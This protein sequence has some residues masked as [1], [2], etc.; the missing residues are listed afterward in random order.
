MWIIGLLIGLIVGGVIDRGEGAFFGAVLGTIAG[1]TL[2]LMKRTNVVNELQQRISTLEDG[3]FEL[4]AQLAALGGAGGQ[5]PIAER[6][7]APAPTLETAP[8]EAAEAA[9]QPAAATETPAAA[10]QP[11]TAP[12][13]AATG[14][15]RQP[16]ESS[17]SV[18]PAPS[19]PDELTRLWNWLTGGNALVRVGVVV[20]FFGVAFLLKYAY[21]HTH[22]PIEVR[23]TGVAIGAIV[24]LV[25]GWRLRAR[26]PVY[27]L[28]VQGGGIGVL[29]LVVFGSFRLFKLLPGEAA[30]VLLIAIAVLSAM[31]AILQ[32][33]QSLAVLAVSGGFLAPVLAST[34][35][36]SHVM[37]FSY[38]AVL[39]LGIL[40][41][42]F[43]KAWRPLNVLGFFFTFGIGSLWGARFYRDELF[44]S[45]EPFLV[46][47]TLMYIA[48][49]IMFAFRQ[50]PRLKHYVDSTL[51][52]G[53]PLVAFG[54]QARLVRPFEYGAA[55]SAVALAALYLGLAALLYQRKRETL[56]MLVE[57]FLALGIIFITLAIPL[58]VD[59]RWTSAAWA[60]E[61]AA[62]Y[63]VGVHQ[64]RRAPRVFG[65]L[66]QF[67][68]GVA[69][70]GDF[71]STTGDTPVLN[72]FYMGTVFIAL[73]GLFSNY[74]IERHAA[75][76][77]HMAMQV[78]IAVF[79]WGLA[80][81]VF[82]GLNEIEQHVPRAQRL[83][84][85]LLFLSVSCTVFSVL[86]G[87]GWWIARF[88]ALGLAP[89]MAIALLLMYLGSLPAHPLAGFG[90][91]A[92]PLAFVLHFFILRRDETV[93][94]TQSERGI[95]QLHYVAVAHAAGVWLLAA[96]GAL[97]LSWQID[98]VVASTRTWS[99]IAWALV[100]VVL[101]I[102]GSSRTVQ[103]HWP[104]SVNKQSYLWN[105][106]LPL[107][108]FV[109]VWSLYANWVSDGDPAPLPY[110][111]FLNPLD[112]AQ[113]LVFAAAIAWWRSLQP[114]GIKQA[115]EL[116]DNWKWGLFGG[117]VF[118]WLNGVL[119]RSL[120][121]WGG[122]PHDFG[123]M[124][125]SALAQTAVSIFWTVLALAAML[126]ATRR[127]NRWLW[128]TGAALMAVVVVK[129][130]VIDLAKVG[131]V[132]RIVSFLA[133]GVLMLVI[134]YVAPVPPRQK[135]EAA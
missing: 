38:Y 50:A 67:A 120:H 28:A 60:L 59:G 127:Y 75:K 72:T 115:A 31:L 27:A 10:A 44:A 57:A 63:W 114:A 122:V 30:F 80:W 43:Y 134:G 96:A 128:L 133:V 45:T 74:T 89:L 131:G 91:L 104:V 13:A 84:A 132:E 110:L 6:E 58:A 87:R 73:A 56:R 93:R 69:F 92:W 18:P 17:A 7:A 105:G 24:M 4:R 8:A 83:S 68:A 23:L 9:P 79:V 62:A 12:A 41:I 77:G 61:G 107:V 113:M 3:L 123:A 15:E 94:T 37:L 5:A 111:P 53:T 106:I 135:T 98:Q 125:R 25:I 48:I 2:S 11:T 71:R 108:G 90:L 112:I 66:L 95:Q 103:A 88:P 35:G 26:N 82:G 14:S 121:H 49:S 16:A 34:G 33:A 22:V 130:F 55:W 109:F 20:L 46:L 124:L 40:A 116:P 117:I 118:Y 21:E 29:Y 99:L 102:A 129:L 85:A 52:F 42:A 97:E 119:L 39:N 70:L 126:F 65:L 54:L 32:S 81:W 101:M 47:F 19:T 86:F 64:G 51:I 78:A 76:V 36:G 1:L 100:P